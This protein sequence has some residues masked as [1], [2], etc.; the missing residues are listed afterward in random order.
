MTGAV[1]AL[2]RRLGTPSRLAYAGAG[3]SLFWLFV[4]LAAPWLAPFDPLEQNLKAALLPPGGTHLLGTDNFGRDLLS[5]P[6][7]S[8]PRRCA[9]P[10]G[11]SAACKSCSSGSNGASQGAATATNSQNRLI[12]APA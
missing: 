11:S 9:P 10:G 3:I 12:P 5:R 6:K 8:V 1:L 2:H 7:L 4:A